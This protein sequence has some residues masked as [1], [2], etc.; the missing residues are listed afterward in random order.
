MNKKILSKLKNFKF[1]ICLSLIMV[2]AFFVGVAFAEEKAQITVTVDKESYVRGTD[3]Y[4]TLKVNL[5][6][7]SEYA[8]LTYRISYDASA[9]EVESVD[10]DNEDW[11]LAGY[12]FVAGT[13]SRDDGNGRKSLGTS[14]VFTPRS[15]KENGSYNGEVGEITFRIKDSAAGLYSFDISVEEFYKSTDRNGGIENLSYDVIDGTA[16]IVVGVTDITFGDGISTSSALQMIKGDTKQIIVTPNPLDTTVPL[17]AKYEVTSGDSVSV[18]TS[19][20]IT[21][22]KTGKS[23]ITVNAYGIE[24]EI[25]VDVTNPLKSISFADSEI[26]LSGVN[27]NK[28]LTPIFNPTD[29]DDISVTWESDHP[30]IASV[31]EGVVTAHR[32]GNAKITVKSRVNPSITA[33]ISVRVVIPVT[34]VNVSE[35]TVNL[36][37]TSDESYSKTHNIGLTYEPI[38]ANPNITY[39]SEDSSVATVDDNGLITAVG[40]GK[41][42]INIVVTDCISQGRTTCSYKIPVEVNI[43]LESI[44]IKD[45]GASVTELSL[46]PNQS[47]NTLTV[48]LNPSNT[49]ILD[50]TVTWTSSSSEY[51]TVDNGVIKAL[52]PTDS[53]VEIKAKVGDKEAIVMV[54]VKTP[55]DGNTGVL[56]PNTDVTLQKVCDAEK[57]NCEKVFGVTFTP[58]FGED[59]ADEVPEISWKSSNTGVAVV[60]ANGLVKTVGVGDTEITA[61]YTTM[62]GTSKVLTAKVHV[63]NPL[64]ELTF[65]DDTVV[66][67]CDDYGLLPNAVDIPNITINPSDASKVV[68]GV[69]HIYTKDDVKYTIDNDTIAQIVDGKI[70]GLRAGIAIVTAEL[71][72]V[73]TTLKVEVKAP[74]KDLTIT[75]D[76]SEVDNLKLKRGEVVNLGVIIN[77]VDTTDDKTVTWSIEGEDNGVVSLSEEGVLKALKT[78]KVVISATVSGVKKTIEVVVYTPVTSFEASNEDMTIYRGE[79]N[80]RLIEYVINPTDADDEEKIINWN[81]EDPTIAKVVDGYVIGLAEGDTTITGTLNNGLSITINLVVQIIALDDIEVVIPDEMLRGHEYVIDIKPIPGDSTELENVQFTS[82]DED[83]LTVDENGK[84]TA[85]KEGSSKVT[86]KVGSIEKEFTITVEEI[87][88]ESIEAKVEKN[89]LNIGDE[90]EITIDV[91]PQDCTDDLTYTYESSNEEVVSVSDEGIIKAVGSGKATITVKASNGLTSEIEIE[92]L[93]KSFGVPNTR[94]TSNNHHFSDKSY[95]GYAIVSLLSLVS[96]TIVLYKRYKLDK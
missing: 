64:T 8:A 24:K 48:E 81:V 63:I 91:K 44:E 19:G 2:S 46:Y 94:T 36:Y 62:D 89:T 96:L 73:K 77:P 10:E 72:G 93:S 1:V 6:N 80:K 71:D 52:K 20:L 30:E 47:S 54:T 29:A 85:L 78:G 68:D 49:T 9:F 34:K 13:K 21:A 15:N 14:G 39:T 86:V 58:A 27:T 41:T 84:I 55:V 75:S 76:G 5:S 69:V 50:K 17:D 35:D 31:D 82:S 60:D 95:V 87:H 43:P 23:T 4:L 74:I 11:L 90:E 18:D 65:T 70:K 42:N 16:N 38:E 59:I 53:P 22:L 3:N 45:N 40:G 26:L 57:T 79:A 12:T 83:V 32:I 33:E 56:T 92:V 61:S 51:V 28:T 67:N 88:A 66:V 37:I 7:V 25:E